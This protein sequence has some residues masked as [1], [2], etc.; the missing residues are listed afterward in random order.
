MTLNEARTRFTRTVHEARLGTLDAARMREA[1]AHLLAIRDG[2]G[3][4]DRR[5]VEIY[6][7]MLVHEWIDP[8]PPSPA[9]RSSDGIQEA[10][11]LVMDAFQQEGT[12]LLRLAQAIAALERIAQLAK[13]AADRTERTAITLLCEPLVLLIARLER[14]RAAGVPR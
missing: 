1:R 5:Q 3:G 11:Q 13:E 2:L 8:P 7:S 14:E 6:L 10:Q 12:C 9:P 4:R